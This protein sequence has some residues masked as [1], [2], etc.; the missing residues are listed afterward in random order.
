MKFFTSPEQQMTAAAKGLYVPAVK[1]TDKAIA[2]PLIAA[3][4]RNVAG[5][6]WHQN[7]FDQ[8]LGPSVG[9]VVN[10]ASVAIA[11][12]EMT[13]E[14]GAAAIQEAWDQR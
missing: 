5:S 2:N 11:G 7:F 8:D 13:P 9:R 12:G 14:E 6:T 3:V 1:G 10:D 4:S